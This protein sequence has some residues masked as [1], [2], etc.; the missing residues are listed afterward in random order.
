MVENKVMMAERNQVAVFIN[1]PSPVRIIDKTYSEDVCSTVCLEL[2]G[3]S[4]WSF[5]R[6][7][8]RCECLA[9]TDPFCQEDIIFPTTE[10]GLRNEIK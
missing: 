5:D 1:E 10:I 3:V 6:P 4:A 2:S 7:S 9:I 8:D